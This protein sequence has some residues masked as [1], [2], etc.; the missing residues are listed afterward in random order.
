MKTQST[1]KL[2]RESGNITAE[3]IAAHLGMVP[4]PHEGPLFAAAYK[5]GTLAGE[6]GNRQERKAAYSAIYTL[7]TAERFSA[8][9]RLKSDELWH[10][11]GGT[12][13]ELLL[14]YPDGRSDVVVLGPALLEREYPL[15]RVPAGVWQGARLVEASVGSYALVGNTLAPAFD[16][17]DY[18]PGVREELM[19]RYP[20]RAEQIKALTRDES[21]RRHH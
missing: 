2:L 5:G 14:L 21:V 1:S 7:I 10:F 18:E 4:I 11:Y 17:S 8:M 12:P 19:A 3:A 16:Y 9:H 13:L 20:D 15:F 6:S